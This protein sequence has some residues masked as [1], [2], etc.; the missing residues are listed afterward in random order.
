MSNRR[1][2]YG[3]SASAILPIAFMACN[4]DVSPTA[5]LSEEPVAETLAALETI[6]PEIFGNSETMAA[7]GI[8]AVASTD[9]QVI[10]GSAASVG[11]WPWQANLEQLSDPLSYYEDGVFPHFCGGSI[12]DEKWVVTAAHCVLGTAANTL[13]IRLGETKRSTTP[14]ENIQLRGVKQVIIH[15]SY[16]SSNSYLQGNDIALLEL[17]EP[18]VFTSRI[19]PIAMA[20]T[21]PPVN[22]NG[23]LTGWGRTVGS[24]RTQS[25]DLMEVQLPVNTAATC[26]D[27]FATYGVTGNYVNDNMI[28]LGTDSGSVASCNGDSGGPLAFRLNANSGWKLA[29][30]VSWGLTGCISYSVHTRVSTYASW[31]RGIVPYAYKTGDVN[32][33]GCVTSADSAIVKAYLNSAP[34]ADNILVDVNNDGTV[35]AADFTSVVANLESG[36]TPAP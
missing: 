28:C 13:L 16:T 29:G 12:I 11:E 10:G 32:R 8:Q 17:N 36:C 33:D 6:K 3:V 18:L 24:V 14:D 7:L 22:S 19:R 23:W 21:T 30:I 1:Y 15:P 31:V 4:A 20:V 2:I 9:P 35:T 34:P 27:K 5:G 26:N 25:D